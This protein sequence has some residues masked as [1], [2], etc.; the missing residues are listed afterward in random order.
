MENEKSEPEKAVAVAVAVAGEAG[1]GVRTLPPIA[2]GIQ[3]TE[4]RSQKKPKLVSVGGALKVR[5][6]RQWHWQE[7][8][9]A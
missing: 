9:S 7:K 5:R 8:V 2:T 4:D 3:N 1:V 6:Q